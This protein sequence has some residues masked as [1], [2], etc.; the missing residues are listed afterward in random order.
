MTT[1]P[2]FSSR[3]YRFPVLKEDDGVL[4]TAPLVVVSTF[5][6]E[7]EEPERPQI[8][9]RVA[10]SIVGGNDD[11]EFLRE[12]MKSGHAS[13]RFVVEMSW[14]K[15]LCRIASPPNVKL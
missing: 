12:E 13:L 1:G 2:Y 9:T 14:T 15:L 8:F 3:E 5:S 7:L 4:S 11:R 10:G 6:A